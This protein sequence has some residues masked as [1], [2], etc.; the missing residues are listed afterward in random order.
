MIEEVTLSMKKINPKALAKDIA[1]MASNLKGVDIKILDLSRLCSF[2]DYFVI[3]SGTSSRHVQAVA[4][5]ILMEQKKRGYNAFGV[6]G[7]ER[8]E[9]VLIDYG[10]VVAHVFYPEVR[11]FYNIERLWGDARRVSIKGVTT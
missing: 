1:L 4:E 10:S 5:N 8:G 2:T 3:C 9:W 6:E 7:L 11:V